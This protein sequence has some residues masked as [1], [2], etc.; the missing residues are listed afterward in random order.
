M[1]LI[2]FGDL[3]A[4][5]EVDVKI[6][7]EFLERNELFKNKVVIG[8]LEGLIVSKEKY[9]NSLYND[10]HITELFKD[11]RKTVLSLA[12]N[13]IKD[14]PDKFSSTIKILEQN[15]IGFSGASITGGNNL[16]PYEFEIDGKKIAVF[17]HCW[18]VMSR[19]MKNKSRKIQ[20]EDK[21]YDNFIQKISNYKKENPTTLIIVYFHWN[22][23]FEQLPFPAHR[24]IAKKLINNGVDFVI[25]S[26]SHLV[27]GGEIYKGKPIIYGLGN[28][29]I[30]SGKFF[31][32][33]LM[34]PDVSDISLLL[35]VDLEKYETNLIWIKFD[36]NNKKIEILKK[37]SFEDGKI[38]KK[39]SN[40]M[41]MDDKDYK[42][43]FK[44]NRIKNKLVP[45]WYDERNNIKNKIKDI[46]ITI[47]MKIFRTIKKI[48]SKNR[49]E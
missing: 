2:F 38:I 15:N 45:I 18:N 14:I 16:N 49:G 22:F 6:I 40:Y 48:L 41:Q 31:D 30:P 8:N 5:E 17:N 3:A 4:P 46:L 11:T 37:E 13:H 34:Y 1:N 44:K 19:I 47:R 28:F 25:G 29:Y 36:R 20:V 39:Y 33:K 43:F 7:K 12:N 9:N 26:H 23:D 32:G 21:P 35:D 42:E 27:N 10:I 24:V